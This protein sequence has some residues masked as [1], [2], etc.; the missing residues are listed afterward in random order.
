MPKR[1]S[2]VDQIRR[3]AERSDLSRAEI[4][5]RTGIDKAALSRFISGERGLS[6]ESLNALA[7]CL[8]LVVVKTGLSVE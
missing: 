1:V 7:A 8:G 2:L 3:H 4:C 6:I 5:K